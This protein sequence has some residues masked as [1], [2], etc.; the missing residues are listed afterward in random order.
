MLSGKT[1]SLEDSMVR[2]TVRVITVDGDKAWVVSDNQSTCGSCTA[3]KSC[4]TK[5][6]TSYFSKKTPPLKIDNSFNGVIGER[7]EVGINNST[8]L[9]ASA[10]IYMP[11][12]VG[13]LC[14]VMT[15]TVFSAGDVVSMLVGAVGLLSG[16][17][18]SRFL[19]VS[20]HC[21]D[22]VLPF[23]LRKLEVVD[24]GKRSKLYPRH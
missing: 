9:K 3:A 12:L 2:G 20:K 22:E 13:L 16:F 7:I 10:L 18:A 5:A 6:I 4:G 15:G 8:I 17:Y 21:S 19:C 11:P 24:K 14:G 23:F 1:V